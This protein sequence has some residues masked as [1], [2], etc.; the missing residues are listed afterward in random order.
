M[1]QIVGM[2]N[3]TNGAQHAAFW[4]SGNN[5][6]VDLNT[7][8]RTNSGW[9]LQLATG[10]NDSGRIVGSGTFG[11]QTNGFVLV[12]ILPPNP[13]TIK[14]VGTNVTLT[15]PTVSTIRYDVQRCNDLVQFPWFTIVSNIVGTGGVLTNTD[16]GGATFPNRFYRVNMHF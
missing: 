13:V 12:P 6:A 4:N 15:F 7:L 8:I 16:V 10:I 3:T 9:V 5:P 2:A 11:G 14:V 1:G